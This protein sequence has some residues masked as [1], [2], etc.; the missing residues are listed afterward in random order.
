M[1]AALKKMFGRGEE[2]STAPTAPPPPVPATRPAAP[3]PARITPR[4]GEISPRPA[5][6]SPAAPLPRPS[7]AAPGRA[8]APSRPAPAPAPAARTAV[9]DT[10]YV[11]IPM[12]LVIA[13]L[14]A[15][16]AHACQ[17]VASGN[18]ALPLSLVLPQL[19]KGVVK[20]PL[21]AIR[22]GASEQAFRGPA[23][24]TDV[25]ITLPLAEVVSRIDPSKLAR[26]NPVKRWDAPP[27][28]NNLFGPKGEPIK[29]AQSFFNDSAAPSLDPTPSS[30]ASVSATSGDTAFLYALSRASLEERP[31]AMNAM[32]AIPS[33]PKAATAPEA[34]PAPAPIAMT[35]IAM[36]SSTPEPAPAPTSAATPGELVVVAISQVSD[37][38]PESVRA[39]I[40]RLRL[41]NSQVAIPA[42][43]MEPVLKTGRVAFTWRQVAGWLRPQPVAV[44]PE[45]AELRLEFPLAVVASLFLS[46]FKSR[47]AKQV[48]VGADIPDVFGSNTTTFTRKPAAAAPAPTPATAPAPLLESAP[49]PLVTQ[50]PPNAAAPVVVE[51]TPPAAPTP[52]PFT[53]S[54]PSP[55]P[56]AAP[57]PV[58]A[59]ATVPIR[60]A[61]QKSTAAPSS[62]VSRLGA[63]FGQPNKKQWEPADIVQRVSQIPGV[64]GAVIALPEGLPVAAQL[65]ANIGV[66]AFCGFLPQMFARINQYTRELKLG[67]SSRLVIEVG[68]GT[69]MVFRTGRV[70]FGVLSQAGANL[71]AAQL[72]LV[73]SELNNLN[74]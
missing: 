24:A 11:S 2:K 36:P 18:S 70:Y 31:M 8:V 44:G 27:E 30:P 68:G 61:P 14:P 74:P 38:W 62:E 64:A 28:L 72:S 45:N 15:E 26:R 39:E 1:F 17:A 22:A 35:P 19:S 69:M 66:D 34:A 73:A 41:E 49:A 54:T 29:P 16:A 42:S 21:S 65:P 9:V 46:R 71:P 55:A 53:L 56:A 40:G 50:A 58:A 6:P 47:D 25:E 13:H 12:S 10:G 5:A 51:P 37:R 32:A 60:V 4:S 23:P 57:V 59:T 63:L 52:I 33:A 67:E 20:I 3:S 43:E 48:N 7:P